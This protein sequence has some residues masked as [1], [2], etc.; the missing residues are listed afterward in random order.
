MALDFSHR[1]FSL[2]VESIEDIPLS[3]EI[4]DVHLIL[5]LKLPPDKARELLK[6]LADKIVEGNGEFI[7]LC[8]TGIM[9]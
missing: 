7:Q 4:G 5:Y 9:K 1:P 3:H 2:T 8:L 6:K